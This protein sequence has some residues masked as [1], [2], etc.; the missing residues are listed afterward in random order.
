[1]IFPFELSVTEFPTKFIKSKF[2][3]HLYICYMRNQ[4][5]I[6]IESGVVF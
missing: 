4:V 1:M 6:A 3:R 5:L 2:N